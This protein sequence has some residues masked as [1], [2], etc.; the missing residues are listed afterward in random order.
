MDRG[1]FPCTHCKVVR[2]SMMVL[3]VPSNEMIETPRIIVIRIDI[4]YSKLMN[5]TV[6]SNI[7]INQFGSNTNKEYNKFQLIPDAYMGKR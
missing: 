4:V 5:T 2:R 1:L 3:A 7:N 6:I